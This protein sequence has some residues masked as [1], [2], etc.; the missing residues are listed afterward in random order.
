MIINMLIV[1]VLLWLP[2][3]VDFENVGLFHFH[4]L[5]LLSWCL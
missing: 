5:S 1:P 4:S 2:K 3:Y